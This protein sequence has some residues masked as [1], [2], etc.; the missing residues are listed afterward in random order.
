MIYLKYVLVAIFGYFVGNISFAKIISKYRLKDDI[1]KKGSGNPG[2][3]NMYRNF[4]TKIGA[5]TL[6][7]DVLKGVIP[8]VVG[9][10]V[11]GLTEPGGLWANGRLSG[12][13]CSGLF[14]AGTATILGHCY[15]VI[16]K[17]KGGKGVATT[18]GVFLVANPTLMSIAFV[19]LLVLLFVFEYGGVA[20]ILSVA[21]T[22]CWEANNY[23]GNYVVLTCLLLIFLLVWFAH[24]KNILK[25]ITGEES[26][27]NLRKIFKSKKKTENNKSEA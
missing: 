26:K 14:V 25:T 23:K 17:Y 11:F 16:Y 8:S 19:G 18:I 22:V 27:T 10:L 6:F 2:T 3:M 15:P 1:T 5:L 13:A 4:G 9:M 21:V 7:L 20:S 24:R 12:I